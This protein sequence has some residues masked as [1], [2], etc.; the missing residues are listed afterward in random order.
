VSDESRDEVSEPAG[1]AYPSKEFGKTPPPLDG[2]IVACPSC[3]SGRRR[4]GIFRRI[5]C[6]DCL[7]SGVQGYGHAALRVFEEWV[8]GLP[9]KRDEA[10]E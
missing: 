8:N 5:A 6:P 10:G 9:S 7:G 2:S 3:V 4:I 1:S